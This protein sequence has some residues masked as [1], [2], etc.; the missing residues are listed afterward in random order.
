[1]LSIYA[2]TIGRSVASI[3]MCCRSLLSMALS[4]KNFD[5]SLMEKGV[6]FL[7]VNLTMYFVNCAEESREKKMI[8][9]TNKNSFLIK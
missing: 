7:S 3:E 5:G 4:D 8:I 2:G 6:P 9:I 1:M